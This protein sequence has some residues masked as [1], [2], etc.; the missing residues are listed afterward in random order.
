MILTESEEKCYYDPVTRSWI[1][2]G[3]QP[4]APKVIPKPPSMAEKKER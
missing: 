2:E 3:D 1:F 4:E